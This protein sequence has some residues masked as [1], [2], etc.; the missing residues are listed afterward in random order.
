MNTNFT[1]ELPPDVRPA[2]RGR[3]SIYPSVDDIYETL[4]KNPGKWA[5]IYKNVSRSTSQRLAKRKG[6]TLAF[7]KIDN[8]DGPERV[9]VWA[10]FDEVSEPAPAPAPAPRQV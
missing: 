6:V 5:E 9:D 2:G 4:K 7:K 8:D 3:R 1:D 10:R